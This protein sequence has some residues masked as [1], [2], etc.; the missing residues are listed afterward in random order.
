MAGCRHILEGSSLLTGV[1]RNLCETNWDGVW[2]LLSFKHMLLCCSFPQP[3]V[4]SHSSLPHTPFPPTMHKSHTHFCFAHP[5]LLCT[6]YFCSSLTT[7]EPCSVLL[8]IACP[9]PQFDSITYLGSFPVRTK[10]DHLNTCKQGSLWENFPCSKLWCKRPL[11]QGAGWC[12]HPD[13]AVGK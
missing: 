1:G 4:C 10:S 3:C 5:F 13:A 7:L 2:G 12:D 11:E 9:P 8:L 6:P